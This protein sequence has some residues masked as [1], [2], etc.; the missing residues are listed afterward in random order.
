M[1][2]R[3]RTNFFCNRD[4]S[5][6]WVTWLSNE[7]TRINDIRI[8][9]A[10]A[11]TAPALLDKNAITLF[12]SEGI[13]PDPRS[14]IWR[15]TDGDWRQVW[16]IVAKVPEHKGRWKQN[17]TLIRKRTTELWDTAKR[18]RFYHDFGEAHARKVFRLKPLSDKRLACEF[19]SI[20]ATDLPVE[21]HEQALL[22]FRLIHGHFLTDLAD[23]VQTER[24]CSVERIGFLSTVIYEF[25]H[26]KKT[27]TCFIK[28]AVGEIHDTRLAA[29]LVRPLSTDEWLHRYVNHWI[30]RLPEQFA[31]MQNWLWRC[32]KLEFERLG[33]LSDIRKLLAR[34]FP[35]DTEVKDIA[36]R[37]R[38]SKGRDA[39]SSFDYAMAWQNRE[40]LRDYR[41]SAP[42]AMFAYRLGQQSEKLLPDA[43]LAGLKTHF[44][45]EGIR[46]AG[47]KL[48]LRNGV[49][50]DRI[51]SQA[52]SSYGL[53]ELTAL[54]RLLQDF[55]GQLWPS[56]P[57]L[58]ACLQSAR[59]YQRIPQGFL[60]AL[61]REYEK[62]D[63]SYYQ[64]T[65]LT[66]DVPLV[67]QWLWEAEPGLDHNQRRASWR[68]WYASALD[69]ELEKNKELEETQWD[70]LIEPFVCGQFLVEPITNAKLLLLEGRFMRH[71][72]ADYTEY[73]VD[74]NWVIFSIRNRLSSARKA[75]VAFE[76]DDKNCKVEL[77]DARGLFNTGL[78]KEEQAVVKVIEMRC[79]R[80]LASKGITIDNCKFEFQCPKSWNSLKRDYQND[81]IRHCSSCEKPVYL[82]KTDNELAK[83]MACGHCIAIKPKK[84][85]TENEYKERLLIGSVEPLNYLAGDRLDRD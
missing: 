19:P 71:C 13:R 73:C 16:G 9:K 75:T 74:G 78:S 84:V 29:D 20:N 44:N 72:I 37:L 66:T 7:L 48:L 30:R 65:L 52:K 68:F 28:N 49:Q 62:H 1:N 60:R 81:D 12:L 67:L 43:D 54:L 61:H 18:I 5:D 79:N 56:T 6:D 63:D 83:H 22:W 36:L 82:C 41:K 38:D 51:C 50:L 27:V 69:W 31:P 21:M 70:G 32:L 64:D 10:G 2:P 34:T 3:L 8:D 85:D 33:I 80:K 46:P 57:V 45:K 59:P 25:D 15:M 24:R 35:I 17:R 40:T 39:L 23:P 77:D 42:K 4:L 11:G 53:A 55:S 76:I 14:V 58:M 47:W 26:A